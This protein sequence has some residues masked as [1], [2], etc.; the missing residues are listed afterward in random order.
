PEPLARAAAPDAPGEAHGILSRHIDQV[1]LVVEL[2][3]RAVVAPRFALRG[4]LAELHRVMR[5]RDRRVRVQVG[6]PRLRGGVAPAADDV[7]DAFLRDTERRLDP[8]HV[9]G[10]PLLLGAGEEGAG[11]EV[12]T[13]P[14]PAVAM[15]SAMPRP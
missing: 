14:A 5:G 1:E 11:D 13:L 2:E 7:V 6:V 12:A 15:G 10:H 3:H 9:L 8:A 4:L